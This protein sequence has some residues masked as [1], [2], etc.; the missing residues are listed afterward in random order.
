MALLSC[1]VLVGQQLCTTSLAAIQ[2]K[3]S[4]EAALPCVFMLAVAAQVIAGCGALCLDDTPP[5]EAASDMEAES[6]QD[7]VEEGSTAESRARS[8]VL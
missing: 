7:T 5:A 6:S 1:C 2:G 4:L 3:L 8:P